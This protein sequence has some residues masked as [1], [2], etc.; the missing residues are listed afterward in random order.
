VEFPREFW[1]FKLN[2]V[3]ERALLRFFHR[4]HPLSHDVV[5]FS[6][7]ETGFVGASF[8]PV[9]IAAASRRHRI[10]S[11]SRRASCSP[12]APRNG[13]LFLGIFLT[14]GMVLLFCPSSW[15][16]GIHQALISG[17]CQDN[18]RSQPR[19]R[20][21]ALLWIVNIGSFTGKTL[22]PISARASAFIMSIFSPLE[23]LSWLALRHLLLQG[24]E[25]GGER[26]SLR[27]VLR[28]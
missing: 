25:G 17:R 13:L 1:L 3:C 2:G 19:A 4:A 23:W 27:D 26:K 9:S 5:G 12:S 16:E 15:W 22:V 11:D 6:D 20:L 14:K 28:Q 18:H 10:R 21:F 24:I 7:R 8:M